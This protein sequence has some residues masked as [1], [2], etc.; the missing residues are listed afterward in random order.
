M[1]LLAP[2]FPELAPSAIADALEKADGDARRAAVDLHGPTPV[3]KAGAPP[4][5]SRGF[6]RPQHLTFCGP[7]L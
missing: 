6:V 2:L 5:H 3:R 1:A 7:P 4:L